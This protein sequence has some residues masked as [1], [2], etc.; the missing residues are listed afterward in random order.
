MAISKQLVELMGG[1]IGVHSQ[2]GEGATFWFSLPLPLGTQVGATP[3]PRGKR[4]EHEAGVGDG[5]AFTCRALVTDDI[6]INQKI[7]VRT[8]EKLGCQVDVAVNGREAVEK[9]AQRPYDVIFM[10]CQ[11][12]EMDG[13]EATGAI[14]RRE[15]DRHVPIIAMTANAIQG[16]KEK[17]LAA[18]MDDY[19][20]KPVKAQ[21]FRAALQRHLSC[22]E[23]DAA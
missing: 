6:V 18:G 10:D 22:V 5:N 20:T 17:C 8:L 19:I 12:P 11:M 14:R 23:S 4:R 7:A 15:N 13:Y 1:S 21:N 9:A 16:D 3:Q 2:P